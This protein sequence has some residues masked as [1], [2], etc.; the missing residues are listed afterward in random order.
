VGAGRAHLFVAP[1]RR[2]LDIASSSRLDLGSV[3]LPTNVIVF[4]KVSTSMAWIS[5]ILYFLLFLV[6]LR[7]IAS[8]LTRVLT[9][10]KD[11][12]ARSGAG[13]NQARRTI[14][15]Q[16]I[17]DPQCGMYVATD[18]AVTAKVNGQTFH[19]CSEECRK[20]FINEQVSKNRTKSQAV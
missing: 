12:R 14:A 7:L 18:L 5:R 1:P 10:S 13:S 19:F 9:S 20:H 6:G 4:L 3:A 15:G 16:M 11:I 2:R 8:L 17:K